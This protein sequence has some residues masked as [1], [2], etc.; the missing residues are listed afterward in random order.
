MMKNAYAASNPATTSFVIG[1]RLAPTRINTNPA[2]R[3]P[4]CNTR[5]VDNLPLATTEEELKSLFSC[6]Q[7]CR[8]LCHRTKS[9]G[10]M[11]FVEFEDGCRTRVCAS[12]AT[13]SPS[14]STYIAITSAAWSNGC[15]DG[16]ACADGRSWTFC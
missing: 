8:R 9:N 13:S 1:T 6:Q 3:N 2:D 10:P 4:P 11:C 15:I 7:G 12:T 16:T 5:Y 14:S